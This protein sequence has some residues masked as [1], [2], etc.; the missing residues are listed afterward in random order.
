MQQ[1]DKVDAIILAG[2]DLSL[3][4]NQGNTEF[5]AI[6]CAAM[7]IAEITDAMTTDSE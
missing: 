5:P 4:F 6:D 3:L 2:T 7:H 1:R